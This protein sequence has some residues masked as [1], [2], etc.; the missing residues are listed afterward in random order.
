MPK[1]RT[2]SGYKKR[3]RVTKNGKVMRGQAYR[4]HLSKSKTYKQVRQLRK[5]KQMSNSDVKRIKS[6]L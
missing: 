5:Q 3:V 2:H 4:G 1:Q 6:V